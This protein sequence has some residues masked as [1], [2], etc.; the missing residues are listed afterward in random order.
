MA[1]NWKWANSILVLFGTNI[2]NIYMIR[3]T[4]MHYEKNLNPFGPEFP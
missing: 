3:V 1:L 2:K 4:Q